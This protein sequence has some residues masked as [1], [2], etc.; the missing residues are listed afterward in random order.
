MS[1]I[2]QEQKT[3]NAILAKYTHEKPDENLKKKIYADLMSAKEK[4]TL[5]LPFKVTLRKIPDP[6]VT[7]FIEV[8][9]DTKLPK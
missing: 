4:G 3:I 7:D 1:L 9:L 2:N 8:T 5:T 6:S